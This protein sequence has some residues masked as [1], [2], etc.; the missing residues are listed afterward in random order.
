MSF[1]EYAKTWDTEHRIARASI[2]A[3]EIRKSIGNLNKASAMEFGCGTGLISF[4]LCDEFKSITLIDSSEGMID[5]LTSKLSNYNI[6]NMIAKQ[7]DILNDDTSDMKFDVIYNSMVL[8]HIPDITAIIKKFYE[9]LDEKGYLCIVDLDKEDG[10]FHKN[11]PDFDG[12]NG[13]QQESLKA[14]LKDVGFKHIE[15]TT[16]Y[17]DVKII[18]GENV[19]YSLFLMRAQKQKK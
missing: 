4:N 14:I 9:L 5:I 15:S 1:D 7:I 10:R 6:N 8:H 12:H 2:I 11:E 19:N 17:Y 16:F 3:G 13:F 18:D